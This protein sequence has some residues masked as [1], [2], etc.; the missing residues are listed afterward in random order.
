MATTRDV[1][2]VGAGVMGLASAWAL[3]RAG[4]DVTVLEQF[5]VGHPYGSSHGASRIFRFAYSETEWVALAQEALPLWRELEDESGTELLSLP[6]LLDS[7]GDSAALRSALD[8]CSAEYEVLDPGEAGRRFGI[9]LEGEVVLELH[10]GIVRA[11]R[12]LAA[13]SRGIPVEAGVRVL[14]LRPDEDGVSLETSAGTIEAALAVVAAG[15]WATPLLADAGIELDTNVSQETV[16]Y[17]DLPAADTLPSVIDWLRGHGP[18]C[19][20]AVRRRERPQGRLHHS[21]V[22]VEPGERGSPIQRSSQP[23]RSGCGSA[24]LRPTLRREAPRRASTRTSRRT[25]RHRASRRDHRLLGLLG[26]WVQVRTCRGRSCSGARV[27]VASASSG[28]RGL[29]LGGARP[30]PAGVNARPGGGRRR[31]SRIFDPVG[32]GPGRERSMPQARQFANVEALV[33]DPGVEAVAVTV[34][35]RPATWRW[36]SQR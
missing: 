16:T 15:A 28:D 7:S 33:G 31:G 18:S 13:F 21:G 9:E 35:L 20:L 25:L 12:A 36:R 11:D 29:R 32:A 10:G 2:V 3:R 23:L 30:A 6:G 34:A 26:P 17:F 8:A 4:R 1:V 27:T 19:V 14:A 5:E 24:T 22:P